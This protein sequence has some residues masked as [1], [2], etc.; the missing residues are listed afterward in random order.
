MYENVVELY[1]SIKF[2][3]VQQSIDNLMYICQMV[4]GIADEMISILNEI[5]SMEVIDKK[6][7]PFY[8]K[9]YSQLNYMTKGQKIINAFIKKY[10]EASNLNPFD[11]KKL[12]NYSNY[13]LLYVQENRCAS[14]LIW[15]SLPQ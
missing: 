14:L 13:I 2:N 9:I 8:K 7:L 1:I 11:L 15:L 10:S 12:I 5:N 4:E 6:L 3:V